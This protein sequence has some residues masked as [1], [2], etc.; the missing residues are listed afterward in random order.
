MVKKE[1][2]SVISAEYNEGVAGQINDYNLTEDIC[3]NSLVIIKGNRRDYLGLIADLKLSSGSSESISALKYYTRSQNEEIKQKLMTKTKD[4]LARLG[5][6]QTNALIIP[7]A[8]SNNGEVEDVDTIPSYLSSI[9]TPASNEIKHFY[10]IPDNLKLWGIGYPKSPLKNETIDTVVPINVDILLR[11]SFGIFGKTGTGKTILGNILSSFIVLSN[12]LRTSDKQTKLIIFD[13]H[14]EYGLRVK[15]MTGEDFA[16]G[17]GLAFKNEFIRYS[18]DKILAKEHI[19]EELKVSITDLDEQ[20]LISLKEELDLSESFIAYLYEF[21]RIINQVIEKHIEKMNHFPELKDK[22]HKAWILYL[23]GYFDTHDNIVKNIEDEIKDKISKELG[24]GALSA[25]KAG[26]AK[27][28]SI[29]TYDFIEY[30]PEK[31]SIREIVHEILDG[32][33]S[34]II[35]FGRFGDDSKANIIIANLVSKRLWRAIIDRIM[36]RIE[37]KYK[38]LIMIEE[39]HKF[40]SPVLYYKTPFGNITRELR[41]RGVFLCIVDQ[42]PSQLSKDVISML[43]NNF[44]LTLTDDK[45]IASVTL[46]LKKADLFK[47]VISYLKRQEVLIFGEAVKIPVVVRVIEYKKFIEEMKKIYNSTIEKTEL[48]GF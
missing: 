18:A 19:L 36:N 9:L 20:D 45:D 42:T 33:R 34:V 14:S 7:L 44:V 17:V 21:K 25:L 30:L 39:A 43:W 23:S 32:N 2:A 24:I 10:G 27:I 8:Q 22:K 31:D 46:G 38:I 13:M 29:V 12:K 48:P 15:D 5:R 47:P 6:M 4:N 35:S 40:L 16:D 41:K 28:T 26:K 11:G 1:I 3:V 37:L